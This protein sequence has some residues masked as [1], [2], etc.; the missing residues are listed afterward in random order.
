MINLRSLANDIKGKEYRTQQMSNK[1]SSLDTFPE[2][3]GN[4]LSKIASLRNHQTN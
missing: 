3:G 1:A 4:N 2:F